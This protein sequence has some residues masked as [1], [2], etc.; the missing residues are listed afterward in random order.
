MAFEPL[1]LE[2]D[3]NAVAL[4][5]IAG[6]RAHLAEQ[7]IEYVASE[8]A[9][10]TAT[11]AEVGRESALLAVRTVESAQAHYAGFGVSVVGFP[12]ITAARASIPVSLTVTTA[13]AVVPAGLQ[14]LGTND[15]GEPVAFELRTAVT[16]VSTTALVSMTALAPGVAGNAVPPGPLLVTTATAVVVS[17][18]ATGASTGGVDPEDAD[19][20]TGRLSDYMATLG[21]QA[22]RADDV[23]QVAR[24]VAGV[25]RALAVDLYDAQTGQSGVERTVSVFPID[26]DGDPIDSDART[27]LQAALEAVREVNFVFRVADPT[28][29][30]LAVAFTAVA[31]RGFDPDTVRGECV[32][33]LTDYLSPAAWGASSVLAP[34]DWTATNVV[35]RNDLIGALYAAVDGLGFLATLTLNGGS[36]DVTM[37]G[38][39]ALP[40]STTATSNPTT[41]T[42]TVTS[43]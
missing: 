17:A 22:V 21:P 41:I 6:V 20:Y 25:Q 12:I 28:Y 15:N 30:T 11:Y 40:R 18:T 4:R 14:V 34:T 36:A 39:A 19:A 7:G 38:V 35:R 37:P 42:G 2:T 1:P 43:P 9:L 24:S 31:R 10:D 3:E 27:K 32:Q 13:G 16:A 8:G 26:T 33:A 23:V 5:I 29:T